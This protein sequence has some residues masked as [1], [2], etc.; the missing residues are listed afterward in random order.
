MLAPGAWR[1]RCNRPDTDLQ[2][3]GTGER[4][5]EV[6]AIVRYDDVTPESQTCDLRSN[7]E[8]FVSVGRRG[9]SL[10]KFRFN[11]QGHSIAHRCQI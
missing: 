10:L 6:K 7:T 11:L 8:G 9:S 1:V 5:P 4:P 3:A 2:Q